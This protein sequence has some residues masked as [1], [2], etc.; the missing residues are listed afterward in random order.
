MSRPTLSTVLAYEAFLPHHDRHV[1]TRAPARNTRCGEGDMDKRNKRRQIQEEVGKTASV[2]TPRAEAFR[3]TF[4]FVLDPAEASTFRRF[5]EVLHDLLLDRAAYEGSDPQSSYTL[6]EL[7]GAVSDLRYL[8]EFLGQVGAERRL[9]DLT[10]TELGLSLAAERFG[11]EIS[12]LVG[13]MEQEIEHLI[14][15]DDGTPIEEFTAHGE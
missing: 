6:A 12:A 2:P 14:A 5:G 11:L 8:S 1:T 9:S 10:G 13:R 3:E 7:L 15:D 4:L